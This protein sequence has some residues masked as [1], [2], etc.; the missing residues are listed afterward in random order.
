MH[1]SG[2]GLPL[3]FGVQPALAVGA[4]LG[5]PWYVVEM[6]RLL[7]VFV[8]LVGSVAAQPS[9]SD[10]RQEAEERV[11]SRAKLVQEITDSLFSFAELGYQEHRTADYLTGIL[12]DHGFRIE[13]GVSGMPSAFVAEWGSGE[14]VIGFM[15]DVDGLPETSQKPGVAFHDPLIEGGP[16]HGEG[17]NAG[18]AV[19]VAAALS[20]KEVLEKHGMPGTIRIYPGIAEELLGSRTYMTRDGLFADLDAM[21]SC[22]VGRDFSTNWGLRGLALVSTQFTFHGT[23]AHGAGSPWKGR[24]ALDAVELMNIGW[25][26][27][28]E[29]L[30]LEQRSHYS[31]PHGGNQP[32]VVPSE[33]TVWYFFRETDYPHVKELHALGQ[34]MAKAAAMMTGTTVTERVIGAAWDGH[35]NKPLAEVSAANIARVGM[36]EWSADDQALAKAVQ[37]MLGADETG[38]ATAVEELKG[39]ATYNAGSDDIAEVSWKVPTI[40][41]RYPSNIPGAIGHHWSSGIAMATPIAHKGALAGAKAQAMTAVE[42]FADP[43]LLEAAWAYFGEQ[44]KEIQWESLIPEETAPPAH[45][46]A[47]KMER[48]SEELRKLEYDPSRYSSYMEQLGIS[49]PTLAEE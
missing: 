34:T 17:H 12:E 18:Q 9:R 11:A 26:F 8:V 20:V 29:H 37:K 27:R 5:A 28:R 4:F 41:L 6:L 30:R 1:S 35:F 23:S 19:Q 42:L 36:P 24:S 7:V 25:N 33:A 45:F 32:N 48:Y 10:L 44:T 31:I 40:N 49:Y 43:A 13:R 22:H 14:P 16:G 47:D 39:P 15:A 2:C 21:L 46:N 3:R 38:L